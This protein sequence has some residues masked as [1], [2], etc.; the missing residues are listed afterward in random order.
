MKPFFDAVGVDYA[1]WWAL[2]RAMLK[3]DFRGRSASLGRAGRTAA[4]GARALVSQA[5]IYS[6]IGGLLGAALAASK[7]V[8][9]AGTLLCTYVMFMTGTAV[10][11]DHS[12]ALTS[13]DDYA[14]LGFRP[15]NSRTYFAVRLTNVLVYTL[16]LTTLVSYLPVAFLFIQ[17]GV[18]DGLAGIAAFYGSSMAIALL[19]LVSYGAIQRLVGANALKQVLS[20]VQLL[21]SFMV[22][23]GYLLVSR[24]ATQSF[25]KEYE[26]KRTWPIALAPPA[27][28]ASYFDLAHGHFNAMTLVPA[29]L[30]IVVLGALVVAVT[31]SL[32]SGFSG[33]LGEVSVAAATPK[34]AA[35]PV[36][37]GWLFRAGESRA[38]A[39]LIRS[40]FRNDQKFRLGV[41]TILPLT[42]LYIFQ[43][44]SRPGDMSGR[45][46]S[47]F[48]LVGFAIMMFPAMLKMQLTRSDSYKASWI[49]FAAPVSRARLIRAAK[50]VVVT[51]FLL[52]YLIAVAAVMAYATR[53]PFHAVAHVL[54]LGLVSHLVLQTTILLDPE[55][56]FAKPFDK[57][58]GPSRMMALMLFIGLANVA[59]TIAT[60]WLYSSVLL[61][62]AT[63]LVVILLSALVELITKARIEEQ[64][65]KLEF[66]G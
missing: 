17:R 36:R 20:V 35:R 14:V 16:L 57:G 22:Y 59:L 61:T 28:F 27:W 60:P 55:L 10:M 46:G 54:V 41:L 48:M 18:I 66:V 15:I 50:D 33:Q 56:P 64:A 42:A 25:L 2:T 12:T 39:L 53:D 52:P 65:R 6:L 62:G 63:A 34:H 47:Q 49:F 3:R 40:Q 9:F 58:G 8:F 43:G 38:M 1:Q 26:L 31:G 29:A 7:D 24:I 19:L 4:T 44:V 11:L 13:A 23:G 45:P 32:A 30:T 5:I 37:E 21:M 51:M